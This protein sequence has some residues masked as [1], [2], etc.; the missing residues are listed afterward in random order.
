VSWTDAGTKVVAFLASTHLE[1]SRAFFADVL[2]LT[3]LEVS[4]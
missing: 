2:G 3:A 1:R 4:P